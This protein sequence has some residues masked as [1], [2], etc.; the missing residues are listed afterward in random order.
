MNPDEEALRIVHPRKDRGS[1]P[2]LPRDYSVLTP[3]SDDLRRDDRID[4]VAA[5]LDRHEHG[6]GWDRMCTGEDCSSAILASLDGWT[7]VR[8]A[9]LADQP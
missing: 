2:H 9:A 7:L 3:S 4:A 8:R 6:I 1:Y 5:A